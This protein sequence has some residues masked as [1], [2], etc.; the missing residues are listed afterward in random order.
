MDKT[1]YDISKIAKVLE[2]IKS[3]LDRNSGVKA[4]LIYK[5]K[6]LDRVLFAG[7]TDDN[8]SISSIEGDKQIYETFLYYLENEGLVKIMANKSGI[9]FHLTPKGH[10][11][12]T[13]GGFTALEKEEEKR[14]KKEKI[15]QRLWEFSGWIFAAIAGFAE[16][17]FNFIRELL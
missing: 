12:K 4:E 11:F 15:K 1:E 13:Y 2:G 17:I 7:N 14:R 8:T 10:T 6:D 9:S 5:A 3:R 16:K